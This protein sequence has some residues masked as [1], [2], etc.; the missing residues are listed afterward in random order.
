MAEFTSDACRVACE[1]DERQSLL[2]VQPIGQPCMSDWRRGTRTGGDTLGLVAAG[3]E[4]QRQRPR[5]P[6]NI[7]KADAFRIMR[8][9]CQRQRRV[10]RRAD[11]RASCLRLFMI[12]ER[13]GEIRHKPISGYR[14]SISHLPQT[15]RHCACQDPSAERENRDLVKSVCHL[16]VISHMY[17][18]SRIRRLSQ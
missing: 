7:A 16:L 12:H 10:L 9:I 5:E 17:V 8:H 13:I 14:I 3:Q 15:G 4:R 11:C 1:C 18:V 6:R 2:L